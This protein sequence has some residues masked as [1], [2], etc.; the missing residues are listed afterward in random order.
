VV[1]QVNAGFHSKLRDIKINLNYYRLK[2][3]GLDE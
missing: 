1:V 3:I 2:A